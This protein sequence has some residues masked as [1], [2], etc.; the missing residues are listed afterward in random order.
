VSRSVATPSVWLY[1]DPP[2]IVMSEGVADHVGAWFFIVIEIVW[3]T[4]IA[5]EALSV[6]AILKLQVWA[7]TGAVKLTLQFA[8]KPEPLT[9]GVNPAQLVPPEKHVKDCPVS[10]SIATPSVR[11]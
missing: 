6:A 10:M 2:V 11:L 5:D 9:V 8:G 1:V 7:G 3:P 4:D